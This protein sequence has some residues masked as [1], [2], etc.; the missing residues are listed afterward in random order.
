MEQDAAMIKRTMKVLRR[1][2]TC[3]ALMFGLALASLFVLHKDGSV[4]T[5]VW[6]NS[7]AQQVWRV[8]TTTG[9]YPSWNPVISRLDGQ[10][11]EGN[12]IEFTVGSGSDA[13]V[14]HPRIISVREDQELKWKGYIWIPGIFDGEHRFYL[15]RRG[16]R[17]HLI[18][19]ERFTGL[20]WVG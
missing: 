17:T 19:S 15:E 5:E 12:V 2:L 3:V 1:F 20:L 18:Q 4:Q 13:M 9:E 14:F 10:L 6:I 16:S 8:L 11:C 7:S